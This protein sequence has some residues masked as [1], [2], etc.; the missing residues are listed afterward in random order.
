MSI[1]KKEVMHIARLARIELTEEEISKFEKELS[2]I[3]TFVEEL[4]EVDAKGVKPMTGGTSFANMMRQDA[5]LDDNLEGKQ[6]NILRAA[7]ITKNEW[8]EVKAVF[9]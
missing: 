5:T 6:A 3:L 4:N 7:P 8:V 9:E 1:S 2:E